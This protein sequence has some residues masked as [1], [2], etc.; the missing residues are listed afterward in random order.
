MKI[1]MSLVL[2][3]AV[4][5]FVPTH[6]KNHHRHH[7]R[8]A[9]TTRLAA[10]RQEF[11]STAILASLVVTVATNNHPALAMDQQDVTAPTEQWE[12]GKP[13]PAAEAD[14]IARVSVR[15][16]QLDSNFAPIKRLNLERK[17]PVVSANILWYSWRKKNKQR[18]Q[19]D[20]VSYHVLLVLSFLSSHIRRVWTLMDHRSRRTTK[21]CLV[22]FVSKTTMVVSRKKYMSIDHVTCWYLQTRK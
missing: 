20:H 22:S 15:R 7:H 3:S 2:L 14:R 21:P 13:T 8:M 6:S 5:A 1:V 9:D 19:T 10:S 12:T 16:T 17:S 4:S 11:L 18:R